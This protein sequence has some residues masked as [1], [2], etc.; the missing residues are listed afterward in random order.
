MQKPNKRPLPPLDK[1]DDCDTMSYPGDSRYLP[2]QTTFPF[3]DEI[4]ED[5]QQNNQASISEL[6]TKP[7]R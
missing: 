4:D 1:A 3:F 6:E 7:V 5:N 2:N